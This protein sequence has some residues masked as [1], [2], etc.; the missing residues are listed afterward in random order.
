[1]DAACPDT[2]LAKTIAGVPATPPHGA[3]G[4][5]RRA[6]AVLR[7]VAAA[8]L[9]V[10][11]LGQLLFAA[12]LAGVYGRAAARGRPDHGGHGTTRRPRTGM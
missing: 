2:V 3:G 5:E 8:W 6:Q 12:Y 7:T 9:V 11:V 1:M 10:A 4:M